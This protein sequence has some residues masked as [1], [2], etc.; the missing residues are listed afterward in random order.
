ML[1][2]L[3]PQTTKHFIG[4]GPIAAPA[5]TVSK[6]I[7]IIK[8][9]ASNPYI[10]KWA[11]KIIERVPDKNELQE[12]EAV[13]RF[14]QTYT[15]YTK[16]PLEFEYIQTPVYIL[17]QMEIGDIPSMD[18]DDYTVLSLSL[19]RAIGYETTIKVTGYNPRDKRFSH[20][21]GI[22][23]IGDFPLVFDAIHKNK[24]LG[25]EPPGA[26]WVMERDVV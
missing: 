2:Y 5:N 6:M 13:Y 24:P 3:H 10:R 12:I 21:Y 15:R 20:V 22:V 4:F 25:W 19:L 8:E 1:N 7:G 11:E 17:N 18:C 23:W 14:L 16:D 26:I 9:S